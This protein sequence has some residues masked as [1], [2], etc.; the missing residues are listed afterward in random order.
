MMLMGS[1]SESGDIKKKD[2]EEDNKHSF[3]LIKID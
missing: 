3:I 2:N 1:R